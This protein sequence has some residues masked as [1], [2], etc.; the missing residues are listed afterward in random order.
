MANQ[1][2]FGKV[3]A[4]GKIK[5][6]VTSLL[7]KL[8][9]EGPDLLATEELSGMF[10]SLVHLFKTVKLN[11]HAAENQTELL[12]YRHCKAGWLHGALSRVLC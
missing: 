1:S 10:F 9:V 5:E 7:Q 12:S 11:A 4:G 8:V 3:E 6:S 2:Y